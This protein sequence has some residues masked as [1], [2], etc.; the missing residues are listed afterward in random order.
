MADAR[1]EGVVLST[2]GRVQLWDGEYDVRLLFA[3]DV[4]RGAKEGPGG[5]E[6]L[7]AGTAVLTSHRLV[8]LDAAA[9]PAAGRSAAVRLAAVAA[10]EGPVRKLLGSR[11]PRLHVRLA[12]G[13]GTW[14]LACRG[15]PPEEL[16]RAIRA[17]LQKR[18][19]ERS[20]T[21]PPPGAA[22]RGAGPAA[23][24][25]PA[26]P[27]FSAS[28]AGVAGI[29][30]RQEKEQ[31]EASRVLDG[32]FDDLSKLMERA[33][34]LVGIAER[35]SSSVRAKGDAGE[36]QVAAGLLLEAGIASPVTKE[37]AGSLYHHQLARELADFA[38]SPLRRA[39]GMLAL[40][41]VY[42]LLNRARGTA[43]VSPDDLL[44]A[45]RLTGSMGLPVMLRQL[46]NGVLVLQLA[47]HRDDEVCARL[48]ELAPD[49]GR[50]INERDAARE[51]GTPL[52]LARDHLLMAEQFGVL[53]RDD[54]PDGLRFHA[55]LFP[56]FAL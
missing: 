37:S 34:E 41:D 36:E 15:E 38:V 30:R 47:S 4:E 31:A 49:R 48:A 16:A 33:K 29:L 26:E 50:G 35:Y 1:G 28:D 44:K 17:A 6:A 43:L 32:A 21:P 23:S 25:A 54:A 2:A 45:A 55:N 52:A 56:T 8:W 40:P 19:W 20:A 13:G 18:E 3:V 10:V 5:L 7:R 53:A 24:G 39:G 11:T 46:K 42:C 9:A 14:T 27:V 51:L 12:N 22:A